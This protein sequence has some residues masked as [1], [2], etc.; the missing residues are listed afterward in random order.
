MEGKHTRVYYSA[1]RFL[2]LYT[3]KNSE[4]NADFTVNGDYLKE[5]EVR[6][7]LISYLGVLFLFQSREKK[8]IDL[9][10]RCI[11]WCVREHLK[12]HHYNNLF[13]SCFLR[14]SDFQ[15]FVFFYSSVF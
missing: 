6:Q 7:I 12:F 5:K 11:F 2:T 14:L 10:F 3:M 1:R 4:K 15:F 13:M 8:N 9:L